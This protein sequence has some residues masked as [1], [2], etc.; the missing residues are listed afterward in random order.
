MK[1]E[2][3][4]DGCQPVEIGKFSTSDRSDLT[5]MYQMAVK[6]KSER[7]IAESFSSSFVRW[8]RGVKCIKAFYLPP[9]EVE[10]QVS[11]LIGPPGTGKTFVVHQSSDDLYRTPLGAGIEWFDGMDQNPDILFDDFAGKMSKAPLSSLLQVLDVY[12]LRVPT[13]GS[14]TA[15]TARRIFI[16]TNI[17]PRDWYDW[18]TRGQQWFALVR[19]FTHVFEFKVRGVAPSVYVRGAG[20]QPNEWTY[21]WRHFWGHPNKQIEISKTDCVTAPLQRRPVPTQAFQLNKI[22]KKE[23]K[24][25]KREREYASKL[26]RKYLG[27]K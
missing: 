16:T 1:D 2:T 12:P 7:D 24:K 19:R 4:K 20:S 27:K 3:R 23:T 15:L 17:H 6:G 14:F 10:P 22:L 11:L 9:R 13:K 21:D 25:D 8:N 18:T 5:A 26:V